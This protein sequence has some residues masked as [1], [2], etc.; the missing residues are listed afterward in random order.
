[1]PAPESVRSPHAVGM[2]V[3]PGDL[4]DDLRGEEDRRGD[5]SE[6]CDHPHDAQEAHGQD[7]LDSLGP[8]RDDQDDAAEQHGEAECGDHA[9]QPERAADLRRGRFVGLG[10][11]GGCHRDGHRL[12]GRDASSRWPGRRWV[13]SS[14]RWLGASPVIVNEI[15]ACPF[16]LLS[17]ALTSTSTLHVPRGIGLG[18]ATVRLTPSGFTEVVPAGEHLAVA[19]DHRGVGGAQRLGKGEQHRGGRR[20]QAGVVGRGRADE[21]VHREGRRRS[22]RAE[23]RQHAPRHDEGGHAATDATKE[24]WNETHDGG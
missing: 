21:R 22:P 7:V 16:E 1:M 11:G 18:T 10:S 15:E 5:R 19:G 2:M 13:P 14:W 6:Q 17:G 24:R 8:R 23:H 3:E 4:P 12:G 20:R 9:R